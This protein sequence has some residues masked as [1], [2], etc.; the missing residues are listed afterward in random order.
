[1]TEFV[2]PGT[3]QQKTEC[4]FCGNVWQEHTLN[5]IGGHGDNAHGVFSR[6]SA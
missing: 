5:E 1:M 4:P 6:S 3:E 2:H